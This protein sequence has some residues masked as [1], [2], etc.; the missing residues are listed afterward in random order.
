M[1]ALNSNRRS[2]PEFLSLLLSPGHQLSQ[3]SAVEERG[4]LVQRNQEVGQ[5]FPGN[6]TH[7]PSHR[8]HCY[9]RAWSSCNEG[10]SV[11]DCLPRDG[12]KG[13]PYNHA[14]TSV[15]RQALVLRLIPLRV[16]PLVAKN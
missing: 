3:V 16:I 6:L 7:R 10:L 8:V 2:R 1:T 5:P 11:G 15:S 14:D 9:L 12:K 13:L 4:I